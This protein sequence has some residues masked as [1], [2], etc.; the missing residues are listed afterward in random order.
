MGPSSTPLL[1]AMALAPQA[2]G[3]FT[4]V[5]AGGGP[6]DGATATA[7]AVA[8][9]QQ[10]AV[11]SS[12]NVY[13]ADR[14]QNRVYKIATNG[15]IAT[16][17]GNGI[18]GFSGDGGSARNAELSGPNGVALDSSGNLYIADTLNCRIRKVS[19]G[20]IT[21]VA[22]N[23]VCAYSGDGGPATSA[24]ISQS[25]G[26]AVAPGVL[27][28]ADT[29]NNRVRKVAEGTISTVAGNGS[30]EWSGDGGLATN[31]QLS[32]GT[33]AATGSGNLFI[34]DYQDY[35]IREVSGGIISTVVGT[36][37]SGYSGDGGP[38]SGAQIGTVNGIAADGAGNLYLGDNASGCRIREV[39][40]GIINTLAG[41][42]ICGYAG[43]GG[44]ATSAALDLIRNIAADNSGNVYIADRNR[45]RKISGGIINT[46]AGGG[47]ANGA[48]ATTASVSP[49]GTAVDAFGN[50]YI[51]SV[52]DNRVYK[53]SNG[54]IS[55]V[56]GN[57][58]PGFSGDGG[59]AA[60]AEIASPYGVAV[61]SSGNV[62]IADTSNDRIRLVSGGTITTLVGN[63][64]G[65]I[66]Q[67]DYLGD[68]CPPE[69]ASLR[70]PR[71]VAVDSSGNLYIADTADQRI[72]KVSGGIITTVAG[73]G[74][75]GSAGD[76]GPATSAELDSPSGVA[77]DSGDNIYI[78]DTL[79]NRIRKVSGGIITSVAGNGTTGYAGDGGPATSAEFENPYGVAVD[80][81]NNIYIADTFN[82][83]IR[84]VSGGIITTVA[85]N[86]TY[87]YSGDG[88]LA[89]NAELEE[90]YG[91]AVDASDNIYIADTGNHRIREV[92]TVNGNVISTIAGNGFSSYSGDGGQ[93]TGA[94]LSS[95]N[96][97]AVDASG[98]LYISDLG[99]ARVRVV[100]PGGVIT[101]FAGGGTAGTANGVPATQATLSTPTLLAADG[102]RLYI[103]DAGDGLLRR[104]SGGAIS[105]VI[106]S[107]GNFRPG[108]AG[109]AVDNSGDIFIS[110][111]GDSVIEILQPPSVYIDTP[112]GGATISGMVTIS[113]WAI[114]NTNSVGT[115]IS[116]VQ[117]T[118]DGVAVGFATYGVP[119]P[120]VCV[121]FPGRVGCP[122]VGYTYQLNASALGIGPH[123][124]TVS[125]TD[126]DATPDT[127]SASVQVN[128]TTPPPAVYIDAPAPGSGISGTVYILG[129]AI[130]NTGTIGTAISSIQVKVD[131][132]VVGTATYGVPRPDV[133][134]AYP[135]R[136]GCP[137]VGFTFTL[138][139]GLLSPGPH[140]I[141]VSAT[142]SDQTPDVGSA[143]VM[144]TVAVTPPTVVIDVPAPGSSVSGFTMA[145]GW[146][147]SNTSVPIS[148]VRVRV[149][150]A[151][152][153]DAV[154]GT[155][156]P[157]VCKVFP[158]RPGCPNV[159][160]SY[161]LDTTVLTPG[162]H[163]LAISATD[164]DGNVGSSA[165]VFNVPGASVLPT[166]YLDAP[167]SGGTI[168]GVVTVSGWAIDNANTVGTAI[169]KV[170]VALD[171]VVV[172]TATYGT[173]RPDVCSA[174]PGRP[175]CP[176]VGFTFALNVSAVSAGS[177]R[178]CALATDSD[179]S[180]D[181]GSFCITVQVPPP[182]VFI[183]TPA[184]GAQVSGVV[185]V[186]GWA[187]DNA[188][189]SG[190]AISA[191][192]VKVDGAPV[193][194]AA[195][196][197]ARPDVCAA[198]PGRPGCP[199][200]G[201]TYQLNTAP[202]APGSHTL[203][204]T[205]MDSDAITDIG[206]ASMSITK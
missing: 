11:D 127:G 146:A 1:L 66:Q 125:A 57:G 154:Y 130:D 78:A 95:P 46:V 139:T 114:D 52:S 206:S 115:G 25:N 177:H 17:A 16:A 36:G 147:I 136:P 5:F 105:T 195:Y 32:A 181:T 151:F 76:G 157:D 97:L 153:G 44:P 163:T 85:G 99:N 19:A 69:A 55:I 133:C 64:G 72:R 116:S 81:A 41:G 37:I 204:V 168:E 90:P 188:T 202:L 169:S 14:Q 83:R 89:I 178:L 61:D 21:T 160:F 40:G 144:V 150:G 30:Y 187:I 63:G 74:T 102:G 179:P 82:N 132:V 68:N 110:D 193:G 162:S 128:V 77:V 121:V 4:T 111:P 47:P 118:V 182:T 23:G 54:A 10:L 51:A 190:T 65:C 62:Y 92:S 101:M 91:V 59:P 3:Q 165:S 120:D 145:Y 186:S 38:A 112:A 142:D 119:R 80:S 166:V 180:P 184:N 201:Y 137:D 71:G 205:A 7:V 20:I 28:I 183:D 67:T 29:F 27:Y 70:S 94:Q 53:V 8:N 31:A 167:A 171:G 134:N 203:T 141:T 33:I 131:G 173:A 35:R 109:L 176:N 50:V 87:G 161:Q 100:S 172:G 22:G 197:I 73:N 198:Y 45:I 104:V 113:G 156:R 75:Y 98:N 106:T 191:V 60:G 194:T 189:G 39:S 84:K 26:V 200:V 152:V 174:F 24:D 126:S 199:N 123:T 148:S 2:F 79:N 96:G 13:V 149:D 56:A 88:G 117:V 122:N 18:Q 6:P 43:D 103:T 48:G 49:T 9:P 143:S 108:N 135:G 107:A 159:G 185:T 129:W 34:V 196:G 15:T 155:S 138:N 164:S 124:I 12:G 158:G 140:V 58:I 42:S 93:A 175:G 192:Q 86:G 170:Q